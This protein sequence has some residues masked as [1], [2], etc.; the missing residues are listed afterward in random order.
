MI[1]ATQRPLEGVDRYYHPKL[2]QKIDAFN[3]DA[4]QHYRVDG[5][6]MGY[7]PAR[8]VRAAPWEQVVVDLIEPWKVQTGTGQIYQC[9]ALTSI[10]RVTGL[11]E[12]IQI[13]NKTS[14]HVCGCKI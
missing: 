11:A 13:D 4:Y 5:R 9:L 2:R 6:V 3:C 12:L 14:N 10:D 8:D 1:L 7:L